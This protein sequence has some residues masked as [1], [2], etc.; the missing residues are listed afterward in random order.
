L[1][2]KPPIFPRK[3]T[4]SC[5]DTNPRWQIGGT[6]RGEN[7]RGQDRRP[8]RHE[9]PCCD[10]IAERPNPATEIKAALA[11]RIKLC[12]QVR[13]SRQITV[14]FYTAF[15]QK[16]RRFDRWRRYGWVSFAGEKNNSPLCQP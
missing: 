11:D 7:V 9:H 10:L 16:L 3:S 2:S 13:S 6:I 5:P 12:G 14:F 4:A 15:A 1:P 8:G